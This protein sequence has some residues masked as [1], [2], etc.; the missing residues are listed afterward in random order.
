[1]IYR[2][3]QRHYYQR[4]WRENSRRSVRPEEGHGTVHSEATNGNRENQNR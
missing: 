4:D 2:L 3:F 1:M